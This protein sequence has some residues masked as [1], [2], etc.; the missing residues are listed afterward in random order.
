MHKTWQLNQTGAKMWWDAFS[1][2]KV[3]QFLHTEI[4]G[5]VHRIMLFGPHNKGKKKNRKNFTT[6]VWDKIWHSLSVTAMAIG[7][8]WWCLSSQEEISSLFFKFLSM[9]YHYC[10]FQRQVMKD[11][12]IKRW[13][14][15]AFLPIIFRLRSYSCQGALLALQPHCIQVGRAALLRFRNTDRRGFA[16]TVTPPLSAAS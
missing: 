12:S 14:L 5:C 4:N 10:S 6:L 9:C 7:L 1:T 16:G 2:S 11:S 13:C 3:L 8:G 15:L